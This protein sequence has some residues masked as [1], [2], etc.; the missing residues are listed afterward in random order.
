M[1]QVQL[2]NLHWLCYAVTSP[3][4][5]EERYY[6]DGQN[7]KL[8]YTKPV[9]GSNETEFFNMV[10][11]RIDAFESLSLSARLG[12]IDE[13]SSSLVEIPRLHV[14]DKILIQL[15]FLSKFPGIIHHEDVRLAAEKQQDVQGFVLDKIFTEN[16]GLSPAEPYWDEYK[17]K[18]IQYYLEIYTGIQGIALKLIG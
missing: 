7:Q 15:L 8:F 16:S 6:Y 10:D 17:L 9:T 1:D 5:G 18:T 2:F 13:G 3:C 4:N 11:L 12:K 14:S